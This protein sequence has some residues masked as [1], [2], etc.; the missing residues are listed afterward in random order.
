MATLDKNGG[1]MV[2]HAHLA[3]E[4]CTARAGTKFHAGAREVSRT[5]D[6]NNC[7]NPQLYAN[8]PL[9][10]LA[11]LRVPSLAVSL[12]LRNITRIVEANLR[13]IHNIFSG[14][15]TNKPSI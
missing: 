3:I 11:P 15:Q 6:T 14:V 2:H 12:A 1:H 13:S 10:P 5:L 8:V 9:P 4:S 7:Q